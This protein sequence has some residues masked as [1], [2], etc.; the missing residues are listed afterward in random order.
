M[1]VAGSI[2]CDHIDINGALH[3]YINFTRNDASGVYSRIIMDQ[4]DRIAYICPTNGYHL[5]TGGRV[6]ISSNVE[7]LA[8]TGRFT[9]DVYSRGQL[10]CK[11]V[12]SESAHRIDFT[13]KLI[14]GNTSGLYA[15]IDGRTIDTPLVT[16]DGQ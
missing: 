15:I 3:S 6:E 1:R 8:G 10:V 14:S 5:F 7:F 13:W 16:F 2:A 9:G 4:G 12:N 11:S